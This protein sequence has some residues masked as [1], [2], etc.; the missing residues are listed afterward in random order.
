MSSFRDVARPL[1]DSVREM[2][3]REVGSIHQEPTVPVPFLARNSMLRRL[4]EDTVTALLDE[5]GPSANA[6]YFVELRH[7]G[8]ALSRP[9]AIP[10]A[11][12][13]RDG[14]FSV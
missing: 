13:R 14:L 3:Y 12:G 11:I 5:A 9:S 10:N 6:P 8:G 1:L 7:F 2:P 4:D